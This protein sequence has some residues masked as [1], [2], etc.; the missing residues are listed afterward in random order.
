MQFLCPT[1]EYVDGA[2]NSWCHIITAMQGKLLESLM[3]SI[4]SISCMLTM[5][6]IN[7][8][9]MQLGYTSTERIF[10][11]NSGG[12]LGR[13]FTMVDTETNFVMYNL[14]IHTWLQ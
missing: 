13:S 14:D 5:I 1:C 3:L 11:E 7:P 4:G 9:C 2:V 6:S 12:M 10:S 8:R